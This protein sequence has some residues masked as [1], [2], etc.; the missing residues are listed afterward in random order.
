VLQEG[1][2]GSADRITVAGS[3]NA[4][5]LVITREPRDAG[6]YFTFGG[7][8][9]IYSKKGGVQDL[10]VE[11]LD[12]HDVTFAECIAF[13]P[14]NTA[15]TP[16]GF[17]IYNVANQ[18][19]L[20]SDDLYHTLANVRDGRGD[21]C[22]LIGMTV[23][24]IKAFGSDAAMYAREAQ[25]A[26][27]GEGGW[28]TPSLEENQGITQ[29]TENTISGSLFWFLF[30]YTAPLKSVPGAVF[31]NSATPVLSSFLPANG[32]M[33]FLDFTAARINNQGYSGNYWLATPTDATN[34]RYMTFTNSTLYTNSSTLMTTMFGVRCIRNG[35]K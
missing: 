7:V 31:P 12:V 20:V 19:H 26:S 1:F 28:R 13:N 2:G 14:R 24:E 3:G 4:A 22:R 32:L 17:P 10:A 27:T 18:A 15:P 29:Q 23:G 6:I 5:K 16:I 33:R 35:S 21:P 8:I 11:T 25:L 34:A 30:P 9:G